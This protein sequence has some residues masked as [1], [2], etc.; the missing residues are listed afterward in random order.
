MGFR[1]YKPFA[2]GQ[3]HTNFCES[4][5][6]IDSLFILFFWPL[7]QDLQYRIYLRKQSDVLPG[8]ANSS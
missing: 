8:I 7:V 1:L 6:L 3:A 4:D 2:H 5:H